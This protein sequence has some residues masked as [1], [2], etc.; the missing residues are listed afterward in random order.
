MA[1]VI[2]D[3]IPPTGGPVS[4]RYDIRV[5]A[6]IPAVMSRE[7]GSA[8]A[9]VFGERVTTFQQ[10]E[11]RS[12]RCAQALLALGVRRGDRIAVLAKDSDDL[13]ELIFGIAKVGAVFL[14]IN[15]RLAGPEIHF[16]LDDSEATL[17]F[18]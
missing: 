15:W 17:L 6:D 5:V 18:A 14:G 10:L 7:R 8:P 12:N 4:N 13:F 16:I 3:T 11:A 1:R 9:L 2:Q